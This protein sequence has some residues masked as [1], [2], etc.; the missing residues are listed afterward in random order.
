M[1]DLPLVEERGGPVTNR[2]SFGERV[3]AAFVFGKQAAG[4]ARQQSLGIYTS[5]F[6]LLLGCAVCGG[7]YRGAKTGDNYCFDARG[8]LREL[9]SDDTLVYL[10]NPNNPTGQV[11]PME[12]LEAIVQ[13]AE[14][15][16]VCVFV[17]KPM[18]TICPGQL[19]PLHL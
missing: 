2:S 9:S 11:I 16:S 7:Q 3:T 12:Q 13:A 17:G 10:D 15:K 4:R 1:G 19:R 8:L 14:K 6:I 5:V 18:V